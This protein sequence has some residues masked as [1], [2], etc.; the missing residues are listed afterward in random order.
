MN[1]TD[2][3]LRI[4]QRTTRMTTPRRDGGKG[5]LCP[6]RE[7]G[8]DSFVVTRRVKKERDR[9]R[10]RDD[11]A[12]RR[13][14][15]SSDGGN[16]VDVARV[17]QSR[18]PPPPPR[19]GEETK[20]LLGVERRRDDA[21]SPRLGGGGGV[22]ARRGVLG[23]SAFSCSLRGLTKRRVIP[24][25]STRRRRAIGVECN[26]N[27]NKGR[28]ENDE[29][30]TNRTSAR[31]VRDKNATAAATEEMVPIETTRRGCRCRRERRPS[32]G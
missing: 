9:E 32:D 16:D 11:V 8:E 1:E 15:L 24:A 30:S 6:P 4:L 21:P 26:D 23:V 12:R 7:G 2:A 19:G 22:F 17:V 10:E 5:F 18:P 25:S 29:K 20:T 3:R 28:T 31:F 14:R 13:R 27:K